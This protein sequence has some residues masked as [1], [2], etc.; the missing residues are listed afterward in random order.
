MICGE[1]C[2]EGDGGGGGD[3]GSVGGNGNGGNGGNKGCDVGQE[4]NPTTKF[5]T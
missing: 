3:G 1:I 5:D 4:K 2:F